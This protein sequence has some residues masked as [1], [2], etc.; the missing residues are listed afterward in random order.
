M[1]PTI[2]IKRVILEILDYLKYQVE[3]DR[4]TPEELKLIKDSLVDNLDVECTS[5]D[6]AEIYG[7]TPSNVLVALGRR[8]LPKPK[9]RKLYNFAKFVQYL[10]RTWKRVNK[11][12]VDEL[13]NQS[14]K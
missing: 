3:N 10:P 12:E 6:I 8:W 5:S 1:K 4:C 9:T 14:G 11:Y 2:P 7:Q 13:S